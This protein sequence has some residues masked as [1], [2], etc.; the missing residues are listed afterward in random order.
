MKKKAIALV[1]MVVLSAAMIASAC[2]SDNSTGG[3]SSSG[4]RED[5]YQD[6]VPEKEPGGDSFEYDGNYSAPELTIDGKG[7][8]AQWQAIEEPAFSY[9]KNGNAVS[10]KIYRGDAALFFLFD[11]KDTVLLTQGVTNDDAVTHGDSIELYLDTKAD[12]GRSPQSDD[13]QIN[14][15]IHGKTRIMQGAGGQWGSWNGLIDYEVDLHGTLN[16][17]DEANDTGYT[18]EFMVP[19]KDIQIEKTDTIGF[20][21]GQV[22][23]I[24]TEDA[25]TGN[26]DGNHG[27]WDWFG[28]S[29]SGEP[30]VP[31]NYVL[32]QPDGTII[33][34][35]EQV[36]PPA[37]IAGNVKDIVGTAVADAAVT[38]TWEQVTKTATT[39]ANGYFFIEDVDPEGTYTVTVEKA[40]FLTASETYTRAELRAANGGRVLKDIALTPT[41]SLKYTTLTGTVKNVAD[42]AIGGATVTVKGTQITTTASGD[43]TFTLESV[44]ANSGDVTLVVAKA[45]YADSETTIAEATLQADGTTALGDVNLNLSWANMGMFAGKSNLFLAAS[46]TLTRTLTGIEIHFAGA[47]RLSGRIE[48]YIDTKTPTDPRDQD[49]T[50]WCF[51]L[52]DT[53]TVTGFHY[54][55]SFTNAGLVWTISH[56]DS[57]GFIGDFYIPYSYLGIGPIEVF[58]IEFG[59][60]STT[61]K[62]WDGW[63][64]CPVGPAP[65]ASNPTEWLRVGARNNLYRATD[66]NTQAA[67]SGTVTSVGKPVAGV[68][69]TVNGKHATTDGTG[70]WNMN[71]P[72]TSAAV[73]VTYTAQ[74]YNTATTEIA[75]GYFDRSLAWSE[76]KTLEEQKVTISGKVTDQDG[77]PVNN[78]EVEIAELALSV[79]T[80][81][82]GEYTIENV[83]TFKALTV[84]FTLEGYAT[85]SESITLDTLAAGGTITV[86][87]SITATSQVK[88]LTLTGKIVGADGNIENAAI[89]LKDGDGNLATTTAD[90]AFSIENFSVVDCTLVISKEGY[91]DRE[92]AFNASAASAAEGSFAI[93]G[94][95]YL[96]REYT[97]L[98]NAFGTKADDFAHFV[99]YVTRG[100]TAFEFK[101]EGSKA[102]AGHIEFFVDTKDS[103]TVTEARNAND[104]RFD[105]NADGT[106]SVDNF[107]GSNTVTSTLTLHVE[108]AETTSP[109]VTFTLPY[110][111]LGVTRN[112][113][114]G[115]TFGQS[116]NGWDGWNHSDMKGVNGVDF[117][118]PEITMDYIRIGLDNQPFENAEN[119]TKAELDLTGYNMHFGS[120]L[121]PFHAK[122]TRDETGVTFS[123]ITAYD[124]G[125]SRNTVTSQDGATEVIL[126][127]L[128]TNGEKKGDWG[129]DYILKITGDG[130][131]YLKDGAWWAV[132]EENKIGDVSFDKQNGVTKFSF[133][134]DYGKAGIENQQKEFGLSMVEGWTN[135]RDNSAAGDNYGRFLVTLESGSHVAGDAANEETYIRVDENGNLSAPQ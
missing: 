115:V 30:Q 116:N 10:V 72:V 22:D 128:D 2:G 117:V 4:N 91:L 52:N 84:T 38:A 37:D 110:A 14:L 82:R 11:V 127:Y 68:V 16:D 129:N 83:T 130:K 47:R 53:G 101:F 106:V 77:H 12:G 120:L 78:V 35:D 45:G 46:T 40:G 61:A 109:V 94:D 3:G 41:A 31:D 93:A 67:F 131:V 111:F 66:N 20:A 32:L 105:L 122:L 70:R 102:F 5:K 6:Y 43:G 57:D 49:S 63:T 42:G 81:D 75:A 56:N 90:G 118:A 112:E 58:G 124:F 121:D 76:E 60:W 73:T 99:P 125:T 33:S 27:P 108:G 28:W 39:D 85:G 48:V 86:N 80:N 104:Y 19:Y 126:I 119:K 97:Q 36:K 92:Y 23:K 55:T 98:G 114:I 25:A 113:I 123:F 103:G 13:F 26:F 51:E 8:D 17:G 74:G 88:K 133:T 34:R 107:G 44:P 64:Q 7:D 89:K 9:G 134:L 69:V 96:T 21:V 79:K 50:A 100:E 59:Q 1:A 15:G 24:R 29:R 65:N 132:A 62:D 54:T 95:I 87:K 71:V 18:V 135:E